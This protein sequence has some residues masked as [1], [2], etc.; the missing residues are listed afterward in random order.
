M[1]GG[2][3][4]ATEAYLNAPQKDR[5]EAND[6]NEALIVDRGRSFREKIMPPA[7]SA[8]PGG[9]PA[10]PPAPVILRWDLD[11]TYL[12]TDFESFRAMMR[13]PFE[14]AEDK[15][16][17]P[18]VR[19]LI[20]ALQEEARGSG[21]PLE[22]YFI[23][24]SPPQIRRPIEEKLRQDGIE[25]DDIVYK[26]Q[27]RALLR[28][29]FRSLKEHVGYKLRALLH[30]HR[31]R[32]IQGERGAARE[33]LFGDDW[34]MDPLVY[35]L[36]ADLLGGAVDDPMAEAVLRLARV[37][38]RKIEHL[39]EDVRTIRQL[40]RAAAF[41]TDVVEQIFIHRA[42][43]HGT[44]SGLQKYGGRLLGTA[45][46]LQTAALLCALG[47]LRVPGVVAVAR[48][49]QEEHDW[50]PSRLQQAI[51]ALRER[52]D[53]RYLASWEEIGNSVSA[54]C[55]PSAATG[56]PGT[57][58]PQPAPSAAKRPRDL[59]SCPVALSPR[60]HLDRRSLLR[61]RAAALLDRW[62]LAWAERRLGWTEGGA[63]ERGDTAAPP[64]YRAILV[65]LI[66]GAPESDDDQLSEPLPDHAEERADPLTAESVA[67]E[68]PAAAPDEEAES[69][70]EMSAPEEQS[71][72]D[73]ATLGTPR[74]IAEEA[75][76]PPTGDA[77]PQQ[78]GGK[79]QERKHGHHPPSS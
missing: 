4:L 46:Y 30:H 67:D 48:E 38:P 24:A 51:L 36:Y 49:L 26:D 73:H 76:E 60:A 64:D 29:R 14:G 17:L 3:G 72:S 18:G 19:S 25:V 65:E 50:K 43:P 20:R 41:P 34:E 10:P 57:A 63:T 21:R 28:G 61:R 58:P 71:K 13:I 6:A 59:A 68:A 27:V 44:L 42:R 39:L 15:R 70:A 77:P 66:N 74:P 79:L 69:P 12:A 55:D 2:K 37:E 40:R 62:A 35:T 5:N 52:P 56:L 33:L 23:T 1:R 16:S 11:K 78:Q 47:H 53:V 75:A 54:A 7:T 31:E 9:K 22:T 8:S 32:C 45:N